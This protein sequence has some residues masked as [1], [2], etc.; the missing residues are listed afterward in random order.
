M[1]KM[2]WNKMNKWALDGFKETYLRYGVKIDKAYLESEYYNKGKK[3]VEKGI[4]SKI[5]K[6]DKNKNIIID[7]SKQGLGE[8]VVLRADGTSIYITQDMAL[9]DIRNKDFKMDKMVY[10]VANEQI[11]HFK[12]LFELFK[13]LGYKFADKCIHIPYG[14]I[15]LPS[16]K[17]KSREGTIIDADNLADEMK[18]LAKKGILKRNKEISK[19]ELN[20]IS[21]Q[22]AMGALKFFMLKY[23]PMKDFTYNPK[24]S[25]KFEGET[26]PYIQYSI[27]RIKSILKKSK[28]ELKD[29]NYSLLQDETE[30]KI[31]TLLSNYPEIIKESTDQYKISLLCRYIIELAKEFNTFYH[32]CKVIDNKNKELTKARL[33]LIKSTYHVL[34]GGLKLLGIETP[35]KM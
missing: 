7:L 1:M 33:A 18:E 27:V 19:K 34:E 9:A 14:M 8:K 15:Y 30:Q 32:K 12:V 35:S 10:I 26:G 21:E 3:L 22:I 2:V 24:E 28:I 5:L 31:I 11:Y 25:I 16:G 6:K 17:M 23:D 4:K 29:I 13:S 20:K